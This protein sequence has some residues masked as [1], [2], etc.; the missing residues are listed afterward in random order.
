M[1]QDRTKVTIELMTHRKS[2]TRFRSVP[3]STTLDDLEGPL[4]TVFCT[5]TF[6]ALKPDF[7][8]LATLKLVVNVVSKL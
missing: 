5:S 4:R 3:K 2:H 7:Q 6:R 1:G 8:S